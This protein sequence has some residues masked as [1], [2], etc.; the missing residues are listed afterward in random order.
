MPH[1]L[2]VEDDE[3]IR[4]VIMEMLDDEGY[5]VTGAINGRVALQMVS[6]SAPDLI[7]TDLMMPELDGIALCQQLQ[8]QPATATIPII[9]CT[10]VTDDQQLPT[11]A[12]RAVLFKPFAL[13]ALLDTVAAVLTMDPYHE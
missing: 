11:C 5:R 2:V 9:I 10:A 4:T 12:Y 3:H 13:T 7:I 6:I 8:A 1:I